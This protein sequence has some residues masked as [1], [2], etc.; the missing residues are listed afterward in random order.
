MLFIS[1]FIPQ[2]EK[3]AGTKKG[4]ISFFWKYFLHLH[5]TY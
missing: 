3:V 2:A 4:S 1:F 5:K